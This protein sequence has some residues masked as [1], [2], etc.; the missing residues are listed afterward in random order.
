MPLPP[1]SLSFLPNYPILPGGITLFTAGKLKTMPTLSKTRIMQIKKAKKM[2]LKKILYRLRFLPLVFAALL[3][4][5]CEKEFTPFVADIETN[6]IVDILKENEKEYG[7]FIRLAEKGRLMDA[8]DS[9]N[10]HGNGYTLF[11][12]DNSAFE[13]FLPAIQP[14]KI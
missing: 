2:K 1:K 3:M 13:K 6:S 9:Y 11:L 4:M 10:P 8:L 7:Y 12:P 5:A 14:I